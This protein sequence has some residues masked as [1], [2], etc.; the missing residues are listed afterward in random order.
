MHTCPTAAQSCKPNPYTFAGYLC[1][2]QAAL[3]LQHLPNFFP[4]QLNNIGT[5]LLQVNLGA[6]PQEF[7]ELYHSIIPDRDERESVPVLLNGT[8]RLVDR[9]GREAG[10]KQASGKGLVGAQCSQ[11]VWDQAS[12]KLYPYL[13]RDL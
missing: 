13:E 11:L 9:C 4:H 3:A 6:K 10:D 1:S 7:V 5:A 8:N 12:N 2:A